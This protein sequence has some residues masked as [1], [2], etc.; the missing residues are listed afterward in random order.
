MFVPAVCQLPRPEGTLL[1]FDDG[2]HPIYTPKILAIL[3]EKNVKAVFFL[4]GRHAKQHPELVKQIQQEG[5]TIGNHSMIHRWYYG[6]L[7]AWCLTQDVL[8]F[9]ALISEITG[10]EPTLFRPPYGVTNPPL[11]K[12]LKCFP[13]LHVVGWTL[14]TRDTVIRNPQRI[15]QVIR[16]RAKPGNIILLHDRCAATTEALPKVIDYLRA[17]ASLRPVAADFFILEK[18]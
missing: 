4:I 18:P 2:P 13:R 11:A 8:Q 17:D 15:V 16:K 14:R 6:F 9:N 5:H 10:K 3:R 7:P 1:T 12:A